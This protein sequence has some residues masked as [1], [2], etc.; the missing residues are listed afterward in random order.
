MD[1]RHFL[2]RVARL[3]QGAALGAVVLPGLTLLRGT[4][5]DA[6]PAPPA[7]HPLRPPGALPEPEFR[8]ACT[9]CYLCAEV[10]EPECIR[11]PGRIVGTQPHL[12]R[13]TGSMR[14]AAQRP[15]LWDG[16]DTPYVL[17]WERA[18]NLCMRCGEV[19]P[20]PALTPIADDRESIAAGVRMGVAQIDRKLC[21]PWTRTSWCGACLTICPY[22]EEAI[23]VDHQSRPVIH[24]EHCVGCGLCVEVCPL[25][26]KAIAVVPPFVPD[27]GRVRAE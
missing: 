2:G 6:T 27:R 14:G 9:R 19:C 18:C 1:R 5:G 10:C 24:P 17:P 11:F 3:G 8:A 13:G 23:T 4:L 7:Q 22:R 12:P 26:Y 21:L 20:T 15:P 25:R 16:G